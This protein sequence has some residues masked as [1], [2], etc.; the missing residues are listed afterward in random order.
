MADGPNLLIIHTDQQSSWTLGAYG[1]Q[2]VDTP[3]T[4]R[5][6]RQG[7]RFANFFTNSALCTPSRGCFV[8]GRYPHCHGAYANNLELA[9]DE[10]TLAHVLAAAGYE[11]GY[12]GKWHLDGEPRPGWLGPGRSMGFEHCRWMFN[13]GHYKRVI[14]RDGQMPDM[15]PEQAPGRYTTDWLADKT[16]E[17]LRRPRGAPFFWMVSMPDPHTPFNV[18]QPYAAMYDP[19]DMPIPATFHQEHL[20]SWAERV[21]QSALDEARQANTDPEDLLRRRKA[22][23]CGEVKCIDDNVGRILS[24]LDEMGVLDDTVVV[25]STDHGEY[26]GEHGLYYKNHVYETAYRIPLLIRWPAAIPAG[27]VVDRFVTTVDFQQTVLGLLGMAGSGR[28]QGH[29][30]SPL[31]RRRQA[32]W[33][34][35]A[36]L[37][38]D[39]F[40]FAGIFTPQYELGL[41]RCGEHVLFDRV[42]DP[43]QVSNLIDDPSHRAMAVELAERVVEHN[44]RLASP[45]MSWLDGLSLV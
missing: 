22:A 23:Y 18:R 35:E 3:N 41:S 38:H 21:R 7:A 33:T 26:M 5:I 20:P 31:L 6:G 9:R 28:E 13:R 12:A 10:V 36:F 39:Q 25:F 32:D 34:D 45:A 11:T 44:R 2:L 40:D 4:D 17:F 24:S 29:D 42:A 43:E 27:T 16:I 14:E 37:H 15:G 1:G 30:A 19:A 8:T